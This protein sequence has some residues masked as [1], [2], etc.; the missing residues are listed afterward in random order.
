MGELKESLGAVEPEESLPPLPPMA[1]AMAFPTTVKVGEQVLF[2]SAGSSDPEGRKLVALWNFND[3]TRGTGAEVR[4]AFA[5][6]GAYRVELTISDPDGLWDAAALDVVV[7]PTNLP[8]LAAIQALDARGTDSTRTTP[9]TPLTFRALA[10]DPEGA[11]LD[12]SWDFG[13]GLVATEAEA[14]HAWTS[15]GRWTVTLRAT[16]AGGAVNRSTV[17]IAVDHVMTKTG[18]VTPSEASAAFTFPGGPAEALVASVAYDA[19]FGANDVVLSIVDAAGHELGRST[20]TPTTAA[21][22]AFEEP[23]A[24]DAAA[25]ARAA[26]GEW[27][28][29]VD[30]VNGVRVPFTATLELRY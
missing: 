10:S 12:L 17:T 28:L 9:G 6:P 15:P 19:S 1:K 20:A 11:P 18:A 14:K 22:G 26:P 16:D 21:Q 2:T 27:S 7:T 25:L 29:V 13:D 5:K 3:G 4:H 24:L 23:I 8:P 30:R